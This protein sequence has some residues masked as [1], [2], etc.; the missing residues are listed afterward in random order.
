MFILM[1]QSAVVLLHNYKGAFFDSPYVDAFG[2][3][4][5]NMRRG[6]PLTLSHVRYDRLRALYAAHQIPDEIRRY[7]DTTGRQIHWPSF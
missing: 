2:E 7:Q 1:K 4:D 5:P 3:A 6:K